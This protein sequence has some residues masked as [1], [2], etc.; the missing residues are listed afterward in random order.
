MNPHKSNAT[1]K[2]ITMADIAERSGFS[3]F[4]VSLALRDD[5]R[6]KESTRAHIRTVAAE[7]GY[8]PNH[9]AAARRMALRK[10]GKD[11]LNRTVALIFTTDS[12]AVNYFARLLRSVVLE[13]SER[14]YSLALLLIPPHE[15]APITMPD[16]FARGDIDGLIWGRASMIN[17]SF[18]NCGNIPCC[19]RGQWCQCCR[20][21]YRERIPSSLSITARAGIWPPGTYWNSATAICCSSAMRSPMPISFFSN[22]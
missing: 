1:N 2:M 6:I 16:K 22:G 13:L 10:Q 15:E 9:H 5:P 18:R 7:L 20:R 8:N 19:T 21:K 14:R 11:L 12:T 3:K 4:A 17:H